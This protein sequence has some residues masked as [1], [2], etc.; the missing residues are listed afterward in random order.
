M[1]V[2][3]NTMAPY[4]RDTTVA[5]AGAVGK[6]ANGTG[7][8]SPDTLAIIVEVGKHITS[9]AIIRRVRT[10]LQAMGVIARQA[11]MV[12]SKVSGGTWQLQALQL[13]AQ[14][15]KPDRPCGLSRPK[16]TV[17]R[18]LHRRVDHQRGPVAGAGEVVASPA[19]GKGPEQ[20]AVASTVGEAMDE[21]VG[22]AMRPV[23]SQGVPEDHVRPLCGHHPSSTFTAKV[24]RR[25][26][27]GKATMG[28]GHNRPTRRDSTDDS[29]RC[30]PQ[31]HTISC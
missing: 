17:R 5:G 3:A 11:N 8:A 18:Q 23:V 28:T 14:R 6:E 25:S 13:Q 30:V 7:A 15:R 21:A 22:T 29:K 27:D 16:L 24:P 12:I 4:S 20:V 2:V 9:E 31:T 26:V 10:D 19:A 1:Q